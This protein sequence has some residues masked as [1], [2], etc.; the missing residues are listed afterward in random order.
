M[1]ATQAERGTPA[2]RN[3]LRGAIFI[4]ATSSIGPAFLT[5]TSLFT[6]SIWRVSPSRS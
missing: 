1:Q 5:Q 3:V 2:Q 4:M 6:E